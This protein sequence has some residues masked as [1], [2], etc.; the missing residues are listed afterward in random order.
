MPLDAGD[1]EASGRAL[2]TVLEF[3][4]VCCS[5]FSCGALAIRKEVGDGRGERWLFSNTK[6]GFLHINYYSKR[7]VGLRRRRPRERRR[8]RHQPSARRRRDTSA[9]KRFL[10]LFTQPGVNGDR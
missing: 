2:E 7:L 1:T 10:R 4:H 9:E 8:R 3:M 5:T 6:D